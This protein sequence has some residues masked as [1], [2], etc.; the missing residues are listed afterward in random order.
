[1]A[2]THSRVG[3]AITLVKK[4][5]LSGQAAGESLTQQAL[6]STCPTR[7]TGNQTF[8][9]VS[10]KTQPLPERQ[11]GAKQAQSTS[12]NLGRNTTLL[13]ARR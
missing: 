12:K 3:L 10:R 1:M 13:G 2:D 8:N 4:V 5:L 7:H 11:T 9:M 6:A